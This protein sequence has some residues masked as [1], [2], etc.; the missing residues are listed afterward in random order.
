MGPQ[1]LYEGLQEFILGC[2]TTDPSD[3]SFSEKEAC[4]ENMRMYSEVNMEENHDDLLGNNA[5]LKKQILSTLSARNGNLKQYVILDLDN[6]HELVGYP[7]C[8]GCNFHGA[9]RKRSP[10]FWTEL[11]SSSL[12]DV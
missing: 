10:S 2:N 6:T 5:G 12:P 4:G 8:S 11:T 7:R 3:H 9:H 1:T